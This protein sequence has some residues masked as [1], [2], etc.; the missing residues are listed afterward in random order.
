MLSTFFFIPAHKKDFL[1][2]IDAIHADCFILD[3]EE[4]VSK[5]NKGLA[6]DNLRSIEIQDNYWVRP[7][8]NYT[9]KGI[10]I[11][12]ISACLKLGYNKFVLPKISS[13]KELN[14]ISENRDIASRRDL[15]FI[16]LVENPLCLV[17]LQEI[18]SMS[19]IKITGLALG[20]H[21]YT[22]ST[23][24]EHKL[25]N[26]MFAR[27]QILN[28]AKAYKLL[29]IDI[30]SMNI[31]NEGAFV[32][33]CKNGFS[34][35]YDAKFLIHPTQLDWLNKIAFFSDEEITIAQEVYNK[36]ES[37]DSLEFAVVEHKGCVYE[38]PH[39]N[40]IKKIIE[41]NKNYGRK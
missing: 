11:S 22:L 17:Q 6:L 37:F 35:G 9:S 40:R 3:I 19:S 27:Q 4:S 1:E 20:S 38:K 13:L 36:I 14:I 12:C 18:L 10:D 5:N 32:E 29:A 31:S 21:D 34:L 39:L 26:L 24:M 41:W 25:E 33:E 23:G 16:L 2:K 15:E 30:V 8:L 28:F 7:D